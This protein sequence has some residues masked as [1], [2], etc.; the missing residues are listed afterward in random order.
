MRRKI[1]IE[2]LFT[3]IFSSAYFIIPVLAA[4]SSEATSTAAITFTPGDKPVDPVNP[5]DPSKPLEPSGQ[6]TGKAGPLSIDYI[7]NI[8]FGNQSIS[9]SQKVYNAKELKPFIQI[10]DTRGT[11]A[12]WNV[13]AKAA[14]FS[15]GSN[16]SL[17]GSYLS[18]VGGKVVSSNL[19]AVK[20]NSLTPVKLTT[21]N[22]EAKVI[23]ASANSGLGTWVNRWYATE[24]S[25]ASNDNVTLTI[26][27]GSAKAGTYTSTIT[28]T[29]ADA[30]V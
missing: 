26:P 20:P 27:A 28:W 8:T 22:T 18:F 21:D 7:T 14:P 9:G 1:L 6:G 12:G 16:S 15:D 29:L 23:T 13:V 5:D 19:S 11:G 3:C 2:F 30:P 25:A 4:V 24:T 17:N 10:T